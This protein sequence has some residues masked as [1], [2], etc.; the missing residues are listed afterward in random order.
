MNWLWIMTKNN[1]IWLAFMDGS[2][3]LFSFVTRVFR[4]V[5]VKCIW[6]MRIQF[7][8][9]IKKVDLGDKN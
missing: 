2:L 4:V 7:I 6:E 5:R 8:N 9:K 3:C 1:N